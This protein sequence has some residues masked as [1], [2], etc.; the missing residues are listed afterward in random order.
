MVTEAQAELAGAVEDYDHEG[1][2][3][4]RTGCDQSGFGGMTSA[5]AG[6]VMAVKMVVVVPMLK[7]VGIV[8][9]LLIGSGLGGVLTSLMLL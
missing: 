4:D 5:W 2:E 3:K 8:E 9:M 6:F 7:S 1:A